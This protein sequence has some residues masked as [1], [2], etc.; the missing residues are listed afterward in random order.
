MSD[1]FKL[2]HSLE[3]LTGEPDKVY[4]DQIHRISSQNKADSKLAK[5]IL[6]WLYYN[7]GSMKAVVLE[8]ILRRE[9]EAWKT[10]PTAAV[11]IQFIRQVCFD[12]VRFNPDDNAISFFHF[13]FYEYLE[14][15]RGSVK[16]VPVPEIVLAKA[17]M[18]Y[19]LRPELSGPVGVRERV[20]ER[21]QTFP[22]YK[23]SALNWSR[24]LRQ[25]D[26]VNFATPLLKSLLTDS[27]R[28]L[29]ISEVVAV[30]RDEPTHSFWQAPVEKRSRPLHFIVYFGL[31]RKATG[32][33]SYLATRD[34][35]EED[36]LGRSAVHIAAMMGYSDAME[37]LLTN[38]DDDNIQKAL[39]SK[40]SLG[41]NTWHYAA[42]GNYCTV[43]NILLEK[44][45]NVKIKHNTVA[46]KDS[47]G[48]TPLTYAASRGHTEILDL[49]LKKGIYDNDTDE[50]LRAA[51]QG[52]HI[53]AL[54]AMLAHGIIPNNKHLLAAIDSGAENTVRLLL[55]YGVDINNK[56]DG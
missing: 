35:N 23:Y 18:K 54:K 1:S 9:I 45:D 2:E 15:K 4:D 55:E 32:V 51:A 6:S 21:F 24:F 17:C 14:R 49:F 8:D 43:A 36:F 28:M 11:D 5:H 31:L 26:S 52:G 27:D 34:I 30:F 37:V 44:L 12:L 47:D 3:K 10:K 29:A 48:I 50:A 53:R 33:P 38:V 7:T 19:L 20:D 40:N 41:R 46:T 56:A 16:G 13:S 22:F 39:T 42:L 25:K